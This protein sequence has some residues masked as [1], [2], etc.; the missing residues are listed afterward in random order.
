MRTSS[1]TTRI[2]LDAAS[3]RRAG[4]SRHSHL[5]FGL[6]L[7]AVVL[8]LVPQLLPAAAQERDV[9]GDV[10]RA[11]EQRVK[12]DP[13]NFAVQN[14]LGAYYLRR[15]RETGDHA[16]IAQAALAARASLAAV[17]A[18]RNS[19]GLALLAQTQAASHR[20]AAARDSARRLVELEPDEEYPLEILG[21][22]LLELGD[23]DAAG[24][25]YKRLERRAPGHLNTQV[26]LGRLAFLRGTP[27]AARE[28]F[29]AALAVAREAA[30]PADEQ[31][32]WCLWQLGDTAFSVG[33]YET[34]ERHYR[35]ALEANPS[36]LAAMASLGRVRAA[37]GDLGGAVAH[38]EKAIA[39]DPMP[40]L[41]AA[42]GDLYH[43]GGNQQAADEQ[44]RSLLEGERNEVD[45]RLD[46]RAL[47]IFYADHDLKAAEAYEM[48]VRD[49]RERRDIYGADL[50]AWTALKAGKVAEAQAA[51]KDALRL[52]T[53]EAK[54]WYHAG[55]IAIAA[56]DNASARDLLGR[57]LALNPQFDPLQA[58][59]ARRARASLDAGAVGETSPI[60]AT[61]P[62]NP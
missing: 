21:D 17:P 44:H 28:H 50:V 29:A 41:V 57:A 19:G 43:L 15:L 20:F 58:R 51:I 48:A 1:G 42:L 49:Y 30:V 23:Y 33:D 40:V 38:Y 53:K 13:E 47:V 5:P 55:M 45:T 37:R 46:S 56:G 35:G 62:A 10:I 25:T 24:E 26:R 27:D 54:L 4:P 8:P 9:T 12:A 52:E 3:A 34:A 7:A 2:R 31:I 32:A 59:I 60:A 6:L 18:E 61:R 11:L 16:H 36:S 14:K 39:V 22:A